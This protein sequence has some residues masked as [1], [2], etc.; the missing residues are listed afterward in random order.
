M[1]LVVPLPVAATALLLHSSL[2][3]VEM[4]GLE[5][6]SVDAD[7][8][9]EGGWIRLRPAVPTG[10][11]TRSPSGCY[12]CGFP[13][14]SVAMSKAFGAFARL[15]PLLIS[16]FLL[17]GCGRQS[18]PTPE[19]TSQDQSPPQIV[20]LGKIAVEDGPVRVAAPAQAI[21]SELRVH[22]GSSVRSGDIVA[23]LQNHDAMEAAL[24]EAESQ[25]AVA[26]GAVMQVKSPEKAADL[27][28]QKAAIERQRI[29]ADHSGAEY[30]R[31]KELHEQDLVSTADLQVAE[32]NL[33]AAREDL[34]REKSLLAS[35]QEVRGV[36]VDLAARKL[37]AA[38]ATRD[39]ARVDLEETLIRA[40]RA[41]TVLEIYARKGEAV[42]ADQRILD[43]GDTGHMFVEAEVY[44]ND[45]PRVH[46]GAAAWITG[47]AFTGHLTG[48][49]VEI[50]RE[51][52]NSSL[53]PVDA[54]ASADKRIFKVRIQLNPG[55]DV[56]RLSGSQV[57]VRIEPVRSGS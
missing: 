16:F 48:K 37:A 7:I 56:A 22:R 43:L 8:H 25:I 33:K 9:G 3:F 26:E 1:P 52:G 50:L 12:T 10:R 41:G 36:D 11:S 32:A 55:P 21:V 45:F 34:G 35:L 57:D 44:A 24:K 2:D 18:D 42:G 49:V 54:L 40:P 20:C 53:A 6:P 14:Y 17:S 19:P 38:I 46:E 51:A 29:L 47:Q 13:N 5:P 30:Q 28:A 27:A 39:R 4:P 15:I 23:V 31:K